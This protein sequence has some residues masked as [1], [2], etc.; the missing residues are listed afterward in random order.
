MCVS[1]WN[2]SR[3]RRIDDASR[4]AYFQGQ[5]ASLRDAITIDHVPVKSYF[6]WSFLDNF[7]WASGLQA[8]FGSVHVDFE[9]MERRVKRSGGVVPQ[10]FRDN[11]IPVEGK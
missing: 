10:F 4:V 3:I 2:R 1:P 7:E 5:L 6:A 8:R 11:A 9:T